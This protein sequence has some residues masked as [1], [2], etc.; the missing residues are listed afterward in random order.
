MNIS[1]T[2]YG[3]GFFFSKNKTE[4]KYVEMIDFIHIQQ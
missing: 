1:K 2:N 4:A 3:S